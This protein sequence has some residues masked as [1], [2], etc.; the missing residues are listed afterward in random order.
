LDQPPFAQL[1]APQAN[2]LAAVLEL[3]AVWE[4]VPVAAA[5]TTTGELLRGLTAKQRAF[6]AYRAQQLA[7][8]RQFRPAHHG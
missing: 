7:Y 3:E 6:D 5:G 1:S 2:A 4:N 8:N